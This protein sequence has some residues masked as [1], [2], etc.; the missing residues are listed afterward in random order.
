MN[1]NETEYTERTID[2]SC[3]PNLRML[4]NVAA[5]RPERGVTRRRV[6]RASVGE[7][8]AYPE[9]LGFQG[10]EAEDMAW[11]NEVD[12]P[13]STGHVKCQMA[14]VAREADGSLCCLLEGRAGGRCRMTMTQSL[15]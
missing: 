11:P 1:N 10:V 3:S 2:N 5:S 15:G 7:H 6:G 14:G 8:T 12:V 4:L 9:A 13:S